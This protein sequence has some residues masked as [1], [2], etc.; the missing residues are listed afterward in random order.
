VMRPSYR[1]SIA[2]LSR[3]E[4]PKGH[5]ER[6]RPPPSALGEHKKQPSLIEYLTAL[7]VQRQSEYTTS[8]VTYQVETQ[9]PKPW[10]E[11]LRLEPFIPK[12]TFDK[13]H[14]DARRP[15]KESLKER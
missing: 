13:V 8:R 5:L 11:N 4:I 1:Q 12:H 14:K 3:A 15:L 6:I 2:I 10:P 9:E 7:K